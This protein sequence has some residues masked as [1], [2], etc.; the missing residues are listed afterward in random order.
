[1][2]DPGLDQPHAG[3]NPIHDDVPETARTVPLWRRRVH[4]DA[5]LS[6]AVDP[7]ARGFL[8]GGADGVV[9][10]SDVAR[11]TSDVSTTANTATSSSIS[12][13][14]VWSTKPRVPAPGTAGAGI[15]AV[16]VRGDARVCA[17]GG[18]DGRA[19]AFEYAGKSGK[20]L[21]SLGYHGDVVSAVAFHGDGDEDVPGDGDGD[22]DGDGSAR[23]KFAGWL[24][25]GSR[26][27]SIALWPLFPRRKRTPR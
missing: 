27:G 9:A 1:M 23:S 22:G 13:T 7:R 25:T 26:D 20:K 6:L 24:A 18:W 19:R 4:E 10:R 15:A 8:S 16:A 3:S 17:A 14:R 11:D 5:V 21:A 12:F 2:W